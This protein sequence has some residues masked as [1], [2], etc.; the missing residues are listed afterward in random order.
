[1]IVYD[2]TTI[3]IYY[4]IM[5]TAPLLLLSV[6]FVTDFLLHQLFSP[7][8]KMYIL[9]LRSR[10]VLTLSLQIVPNRYILNM[11]PLYRSW[12]SLHEGG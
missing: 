2:G 4:M 11:A 10:Y 3:H 6:I 7:W 5:I 9:Q 12:R 1:M 8:F